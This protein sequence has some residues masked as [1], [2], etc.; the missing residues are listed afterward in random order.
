MHLCLQFQEFVEVMLKHA[1]FLNRERTLR[2]HKLVLLYI[3]LVIRLME[4]S[5]ILQ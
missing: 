2:S 1:S 5:L 3:A 4:L